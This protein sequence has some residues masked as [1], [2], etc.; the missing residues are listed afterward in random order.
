MKSPRLSRLA[1]TALCC[2]LVAPAMADVGA[3]AETRPVPMPRRDRPFLLVDAP[4]RFLP[5]EAAAVRIQLRGQGRVRVGIFRVRD[6][7][8][9]LGLAGERQGTSVASTSLGAEAEELWA[10]RRTGL[11]VR[12]RSLSL[13]RTRDARMVAARR[14]RRVHEEGE[15]YDSNDEQDE[16]ATSWVQREGWSVRRLGLGRL[17]AGVYLVRVHSAAWATTAI[18]SV[19]EL[20]LL[21]RR[22]DAHD[23]LLVTAGDGAPQAGVLVRSVS[24]G[25]EH[26]ARTDIRGRARLPA[27]DAS[28][29]RFVA[30]RGADVA[31]SDVSHAR[32]D[33]CDPRVYLA[34]GR[35]VYRDGE[36]VH[37]RGHVRGCDATGAYVPLADEPVHLDNVAPDQSDIVSTDADGNFVARVQASG[38]RIGAEARGQWHYR[39]VQLD[40]RTLPTRALTVHV[41]RPYAVQ[42][43]VVEVRVADEDGGWPSRRNAVLNTPV[44]RFVETIG[45]GTPAL[46]HVTVPPSTEGLRRFEL[47]ASVTDGR[48]VTMST[49]ELWVGASPTVLEL[50]ADREHATSGESVAVTLHAADLGGAPSPG[51]VSL[52]LFE[53]VDGNEARGR[54]RWSGAALVAATGSVAQRVPLSGRGP[55]LLEARR[56][57]ATAELVLWA[58]PRPPQLS[59]RGDLAILPRAARVSPGEPL[60]VDVRLPPGAGRAWVTLEQGSVWQDAIVTGSGRVRRVVLPTGPEARGMATVVVSHIAHGHVRT[61]SA[62]VEVTTSEP[63]SLSLRSDS[64]LYS[65]GAKAHVVLEARTEA[66]LPTDGVVS[67]WMADAGYWELGQE[68]YPLPGP[69]LRLPGR[70]ASAGDS[71]TPQGYG[72]EEGRVL[73]EAAMS[74][75][76]RRLSQS[77]YRHGWGYGGE[78]VTARARGRFDR[79]AMA[80]ARAAGLRSA[81]VCPE[82][83]RAQGT[84]AL[85][86]QD[87]PWD[88]VALAIADQTGT[89][90]E[91]RG[92]RLR[93]ECG[94]GGAGLNSL[95]TSGHGSGAGGMGVGLG[96]LGNTREERL[97]GTLHF[98]GLRRLGPDGR[99]ELDVDLPSHPGRWRLE[100]ITIADDG[101]GERAHAIVH[102][103]RAVQAWLDMPQRLRAGDEA[104]SILRIV[105]PTLARGS[106]RVD[107][108]PRGVVVAGTWPRTVSLDDAGR[109]EIPLTMSAPN[110]GLARV[111][112]RVSTAAGRDSVRT[113]IRVETRAFER[114]VSL[115]SL[116]GPGATDVHL[117]LPELQEAAQLNIEVDSDVGASIDEAEGALRRPRWHMPAMRVD[118]L[119][120]LRA[121][122]D[123][124]ALQERRQPSDTRRAVATVPRVDPARATGHRI[125]TPSPRR[126]RLEHAHRAE[127][128]ALA[129]MQSSTGAVSF[130]GSGPD[131]TLLT[132]TALHALGELA[133]EP[134][135][136]SAWDEV[137]RRVAEHALMDL[138]AALAANVLAAR[139]SESD[140]ALAAALL[141]RPQAGES[142]DASA[143]R[144][145]AA[146]LLGDEAAES[147]AV[148]DL[149]RL[150][151]ERSGSLARPIPCRGPAFFRCYGAWGE[152][153]ELARGARALLRLRGR[154]ARSLAVAAAR[155]LASQGP[156]ERYLI[157]GAG[158]EADELALTSALVS[159]DPASDTLAVLVDGQRFRLVQGRV[160]IS[161]HARDVIVRLPP[162]AGRLVWLRVDGTV[163]SRPPTST[164]GNV[165]LS[166]G[167]EQVDGQWFVH[168]Q[169]QLPRP[170][171]GLQLDIELPSGLALGAGVRAPEGA[172][173]AALEG[174]LRLN[175]R[176]HAGGRLSVRL[177]LVVLG[178]GRYHVGPT[179]LRT[180]TDGAWGATP[181]AELRIPGR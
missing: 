109:A 156:L 37:L 82:A 53:S 8:D 178:A 59:R 86:V 83:V 174:G 16:V 5:T 112:L 162:R 43:D 139:E 159:E 2:V 175:Y 170:V 67:L 133:T 155:W 4:R 21:A 127:A 46:F 74:W 107:L 114:P 35:P 98:V 72:A 101:G 180:E 154:G 147:A 26:T 6:P 129:R 134:R 63:V 62:T 47:V 50:H 66:G 7:E 39:A 119:R 65:E 14:P 121:L 94:S 68:T 131:S 22:G 128:A 138:E 113:H 146:E 41:D 144:A 135:W 132:L 160:L 92:D 1:L 84:V 57:A 58:R 106:A 23:T 97:E 31:W 75:N 103:T 104:S 29:A 17:P 110:P 61:A 34:T 149:E 105:A 36:T 11:P 108:R 143:Y 70:M 42:G 116:V 51:R 79:V 120:S 163:E 123:A 142:I 30:R 49:A 38:G 60:A 102:T 150:V 71:A 126:S 10:A 99:L 179:Q 40:H 24:S 88:M 55:W 136:Q 165:A 56:G 140:R 152:R 158:V 28:S 91:R 166:R 52:A 25:G 145:A 33:A 115:R 69:Y 153:A 44:G 64:R 85:E 27:T 173:L 118:R 151:A 76:G 117:S 111:A 171:R 141:A 96:T 167:F 81:W 176:R 122:V 168:V 20:V 137:R 89:S 157:W 177:P 100:A 13:V 45:P 90:V 19:G 77:T 9:A 95:G 15:V 124:A 80:F 12:G 54:R 87:L 181:I 161:R 32:L 130:W 169:A 18:L 73:P 48:R 172:R 3:E 164:L 125:A 93:F 78:L 148:A